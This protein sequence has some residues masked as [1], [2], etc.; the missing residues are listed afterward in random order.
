MRT[1]LL[2]QTTWDLCL[3]AA[4]DI[5]IAAD[6]YAMAQDVASAI[7]LFIGEAWYDT[8]L[9]VPYFEQILGRAPPV[10]LIKE[11]LTRAALTVPGVVAATCTLASI[12]NRQLT[13]QVRV[14][15]RAG[16]VLTVAFAGGSTSI[17]G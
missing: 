5:A 6:P 14:T 8:A 15:D 9:G 2:D 12:V 16:A 4:G 17:G 3:D 13:G 7:R 10:S 11:Q 1:L